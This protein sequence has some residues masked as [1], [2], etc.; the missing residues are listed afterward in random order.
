MRPMSG[1]PHEA[2]KHAESA[3]RELDNLRWD[4]IWRRVDA[5]GEGDDLARYSQK[6]LRYA[7]TDLEK[8]IAALGRAASPPEIPPTDWGDCEDVP[9]EVVLAFQRECENIDPDSGLSYWT[10]ADCLVAAMKALR[11][12]SQP[13]APTPQDKPTTASKALGGEKYKGEPGNLGRKQPMEYDTER[14]MRQATELRAALREE[15]GGR[16]EPEG[17]RL[18]DQAA[19]FIERSIPHLDDAFWQGEARKIVAQLRAT[20]RESCEHGYFT[21]SCPRCRK[22]GR[23]ALRDAPPQEGERLTED[24]GRYVPYYCPCEICQKRRA[25]R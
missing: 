12:A 14:Y 24:T 2:L 8:T 20:P 4:D 9:N 23:A 18:T 6:Y 11:G 16:A 25:V 10:V 3:L 15:A 1:G 21:E 19:L 5:S 7:R 13:G 22:Y 17:E